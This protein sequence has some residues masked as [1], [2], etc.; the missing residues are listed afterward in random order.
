M[1]TQKASATADGKCT[2]ETIV[3]RTM[4]T[5]TAE[6][7]AQAAQM[8]TGEGGGAGSGAVDRARFPPVEIEVRTCV[9]TRAVVRSRGGDAD[10]VAA[11]VVGRWAHRSTF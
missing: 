8:R 3:D 1:H 7:R 2:K 9:W 5:T 10:S 6:E 4:A 11:D